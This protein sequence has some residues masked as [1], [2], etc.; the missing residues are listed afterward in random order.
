MGR[1][2][3]PWIALRWCG[4]V[5]RAP[6]GEEDI[7]ASFSIGLRAAPQGECARTRP[8]PQGRRCRWLYAWVYNFDTPTW[9]CLRLPLFD[10]RLSAYLWEYDN[11]GVRLAQLRFYEVPTDVAQTPS[12][13]HQEGINPFGFRSSLGTGMDRVDQIVA[14]ASGTT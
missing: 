12:E 1:P 11:N 3:S 2:V 6:A 13:W 8:Q 10:D 5:F 14:I 4:S 7:E 9:E